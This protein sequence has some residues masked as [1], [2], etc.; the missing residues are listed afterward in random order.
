MHSPHRVSNSRPSGLWHSVLSSTLQRVR[1]QNHKLVDICE[2]SEENVASILRLKRTHHTVCKH[3]TTRCQVPED[4]VRHCLNK[5]MMSMRVVSGIWIFLNPTDCVS[6]TAVTSQ[7]H[8]SRS[9]PFPTRKFHE[10]QIEPYVHDKCGQDTFGAWCWL[11]IPWKHT[12]H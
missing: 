4:N 2:V 9:F 1:L 6:S 3:R 8:H 11:R 5:I 12:P 7:Q 10:W